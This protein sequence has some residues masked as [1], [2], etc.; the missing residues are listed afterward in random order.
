MTQPKEMVIFKYI[1]GYEYSIIKNKIYNCFIID[2]TQ[3]L[4]DNEFLPLINKR[5]QDALW[6]EIQYI[7]IFIK[8]KVLIKFFNINHAV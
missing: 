3:I 2:S 1:D 8:T 5:R 6:R 4:S 7:Q